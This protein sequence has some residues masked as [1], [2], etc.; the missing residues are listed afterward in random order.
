MTED[1]E[2]WVA[3]LRA[4]AAIS[5]EATDAMNAADDALGA[6]QSEIIR[7]RGINRRAELQYR[8]LEAEREAILAAVRPVLDAWNIPG[9]RPDYHEL[10]KRDLRV[11]WPMLY[12]ALHDLSRAIDTKEKPDDPA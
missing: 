5:E 8:E 7:Q 6:A 9:I 1:I 2:K 4:R 12:T 11:S 10:V 3:D